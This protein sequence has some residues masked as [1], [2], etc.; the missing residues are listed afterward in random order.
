MYRLDLAWHEKENSGNKMKRAENAG[1]GY[2]TIIVNWFQIIIE[3]ITTFAGGIVVFWKFDWRVSLLTSFFIVI[4]YVL[5]RYYR[6]KGVRAAAK[7]HIQ[8][9]IVEGSTFEIINNIRTVKSL[10]ILSKFRNTINQ[11]FE[12]LYELIKVRIH[13]FQKS[14]LVTALFTRIFYSIMLIFIA[15]GVAHGLYTV[16]FLVL[17]FT[18]FDYIWES[19]SQL[20]GVTQD[21]FIAKNAIARGNTI[22]DTPVVIEDERGKGAFPHEWKKI[23][24]ENVSFS[25][26]DNKVLQDVSFTVKKGEKI[27]IVGLSGAGKSTLFKLLLKE[28]EHFTGKIGFND[29]PIETIRKNDYLAHVATVLQDTEVFNLS[30]KDNIVIAGST[31]RVN[32]EHLARAITIAHLDD[33]IAKLPHGVDTL[34]GEKGVK[35]SGGERQRLGIARAVYKQPEILLLDEATSHLDLESEEKIRDSLHQFF[36]GITAIVIAHR[37]TT[38][39]EM[40]RIIVI[41][42]GQIIEEGSFA[43]LIRKKGRFYE[44][45][46]K[47]A[48]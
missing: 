14:N 46:N 9:E 28:Y 26:E 48:L 27:G 31:D 3:S 41:E 40:D 1:E 34:I 38:I 35:L 18:Y 10:G 8:E 37:L 16:G 2:R 42:G 19:V 4:Y 12:K 30:L 13:F 7:V 32:D 11:S 45:W 21:I 5:A 44:L 15:V 6:I 33:V 24:L 20:A 36:S 23:I 43:K 29:T 22:L 47:Q 25:Y 17:F 39:K